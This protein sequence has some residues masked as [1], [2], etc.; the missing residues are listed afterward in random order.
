MPP[1]FSPPSPP[2]QAG[3]AA[4][5]D[6]GGRSIPLPGT[7]ATLQQQNRQGLNSFCDKELQQLLVPPQGTRGRPQVSTLAAQRGVG[8]PICML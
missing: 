5:P 8:H 1:P 6:A 4:S 3:G 2:P 7:G